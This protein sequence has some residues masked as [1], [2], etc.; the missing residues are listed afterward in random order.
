MNRTMPARNEIIV[1]LI[2]GYGQARLAEL[3]TMLGPDRLRPRQLTVR[4]QYLQQQGWI[5]KARGSRGRTY[6]RATAQALPFL[7]ESEAL[8]TRPVAAR[9]RRDHA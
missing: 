5:E 8:P 9:A 7:R 3:N 4:L 6:W 2:H 1:R